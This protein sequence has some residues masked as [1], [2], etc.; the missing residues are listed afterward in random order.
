MLKYDLLGRF[1][2]A[3]PRAGFVLTGI[4]A[5]FLLFDSIIKLLRLPV[6]LES[7]DRLGFSSDVALGIGILE[8]TC[9]ILYII[10]RTAILGAV[11]LTGV[12][13]GAISSHVRLDDPLFSHVLFGGYLGLVIW[14]GLFLQDP[15]LRALLP[16]RRA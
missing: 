10:P 16:L 11:L 15:R 14:G 3:V 6:V 8:L 4:A 2:R 5:L 12:M 9:T 13:G 7:F 1:P